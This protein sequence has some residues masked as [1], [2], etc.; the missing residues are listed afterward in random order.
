M[1][2]STVNDVTSAL[3]YE[4]QSMTSHVKVQTLAESNV[5]INADACI[6]RKRVRPIVDG[7]TTQSTRAAIDVV[8]KV[9][10]RQYFFF[11]LFPRII[12]IFYEKTFTLHD[13]K[14]NYV[15]FHVV[16]PASADQLSVCR[17]SLQASAKSHV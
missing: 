17:L 16:V 7:R 14:K 4:L 6:V 5:M 8:Y 1:N 12:R 11:I 15:R 3:R 10:N 13:F 2:N 9:E